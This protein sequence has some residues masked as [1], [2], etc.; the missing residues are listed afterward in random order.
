MKCSFDSDTILFGMDYNNRIVSNT[1]EKCINASDC[2]ESYC[3]LSLE[4]LVD[5]VC[6]SVTPVSQS[7]SSE[8]DPD[9]GWSF[10]LLI[11]L[12]AVLSI[13]SLIVTVL[14]VRKSPQEGK[15]NEKRYLYGGCEN[16][17]DGK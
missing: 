3:R 16:C 11:C 1:T 17:T 10:I 5:W 9:I 12:I 2:I 14:F 4:S 6:F 15:E 7:P 13:Y 8:K